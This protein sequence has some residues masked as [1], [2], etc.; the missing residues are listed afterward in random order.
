MFSSR[1]QSMTVVAGTAEVR[2][3]LVTTKGIR[4]RLDASAAGAPSVHA[5]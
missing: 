5:N 2:R 1:T 4:C 3:T